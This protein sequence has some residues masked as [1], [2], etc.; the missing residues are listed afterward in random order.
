MKLAIHCARIGASLPAGMERFSSN[1]LRV[2]ETLGDDYKALV[3]NNFKR[4]SEPDG[5][6]WRA[7]SPATA[8]RMITSKKRRGYHPILR[9]TGNLADVKVRATRDYVEIGS[10]L[11]YAAIHQFGGQAGRVRIPARPWLFDRQGGIPQKMAEALARTAQRELDQ[12]L[13]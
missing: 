12:C 8:T 9:V 1:L 7:L 10:N 5:R 4:E 13:S 6:P 11:A 3:Q 2:H